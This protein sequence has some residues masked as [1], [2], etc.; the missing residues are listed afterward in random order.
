[1]SV[2]QVA[3]GC[4]DLHEVEGNKFFGNGLAG[5]FCGFGIILKV[6]YLSCSLFYLLDFNGTAL[7]GQLLK[8]E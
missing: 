6:L 8:K 2:I 5:Q 4:E 1:M 7:H 3:C